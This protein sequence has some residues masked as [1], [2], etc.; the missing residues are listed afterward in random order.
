M[1]GGFQARVQCEQ[2][3]EAELELEQGKA[4]DISDD[5]EACVEWGHMEE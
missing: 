1:E 3:S 4:E 5:L 2:A